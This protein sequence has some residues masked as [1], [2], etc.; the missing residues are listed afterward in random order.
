ML[1]L[2][3]GFELDLVGFGLKMIVLE[4]D[5]ANVLYCCCGILSAVVR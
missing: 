2:G 5:D 4:G 3:L 1:C